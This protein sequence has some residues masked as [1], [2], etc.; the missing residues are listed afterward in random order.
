MPVRR[1]AIRDVFVIAGRG[2][3]VAVDDAAHLPARRPL[4]VTI[5]RPDGSRITADAFEE[6]LCGGGPRPVERAAFLLPGVA[7]ADAPLDSVIEIE[8]TDAESC[9]PTR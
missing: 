3:V 9:R 8:L 7:K 2:T 4:A 5:V 6:L 1:C